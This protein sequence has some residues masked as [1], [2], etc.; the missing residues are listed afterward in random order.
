MTTEVS[1]ATPPEEEEWSPM[2]DDDEWDRRREMASREMSL[3]AVSRA[4]QSEEKRASMREELD[5]FPNT[6]MHA[7]HGKGRID[8][9]KEELLLSTGKGCLVNTH[10]FVC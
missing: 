7:S 2:L 1:A 4:R 10:V 5:E 9:K 6:W 8:L 3:R